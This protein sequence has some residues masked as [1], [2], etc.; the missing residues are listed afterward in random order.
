MN[1]EKVSD[2]D[3]L[4]E[5]SRTGETLKATTTEGTL[6]YNSATK[7]VSPSLS[8]RQVKWIEEDFKRKKKNYVF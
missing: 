8:T 4:L 1:S 5:W 2:M 3:I 6:L 7:F